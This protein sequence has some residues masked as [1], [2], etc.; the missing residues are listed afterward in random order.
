MCVCGLGPPAPSHRLPNPTNTSFA[1]RHRENKKPPPSIY[2]LHVLYV[3]TY[4]DA[5]TPNFTCSVYVHVHTCNMYDGYFIIY[6]PAAA[7]TGCGAPLREE[8]MT[9]FLH[10]IN[11]QCFILYAT[12]YSYTTTRVAC[13]LF[14]SLEKK[15]KRNT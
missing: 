1:Q 13:S 12:Y 2:R 4:T 9:S 14:S 3:H 15:P 10:V 7:A 11:I 5:S 8:N 6:N